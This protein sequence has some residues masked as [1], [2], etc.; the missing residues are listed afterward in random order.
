MNINQNLFTGV[1]TSIVWALS[2]YRK[3][4]SGFQLTRQN[5]FCN[6]IIKPHNTIV[7]P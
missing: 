2:F 5:Y 3:S 4:Y 7:F 1:P 6:Y